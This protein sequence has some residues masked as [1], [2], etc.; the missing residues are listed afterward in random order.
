M[1]EANEQ[2]FEIGM[3]SNIDTKNVA[4]DKTVEASPYS[5]RLGVYHFVM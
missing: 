4:G 3:S 5:V 2:C 1:I